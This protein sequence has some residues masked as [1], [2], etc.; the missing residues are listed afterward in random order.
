MTCEEEIQTQQPRSRSEQ[1]RD[2]R[3]AIRQTCL[4]GREILSVDSRASVAA[5][6]IRKA[7]VCAP[8]KNVQRLD[9]ALKVTQTTYRL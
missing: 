9:P 3:K 5:I 4:H 7:V 1:R 2:A 6:T 8:N